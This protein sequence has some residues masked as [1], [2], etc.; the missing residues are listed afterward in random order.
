VLDPFAGT[1]STSIAAVQAGRNS[2]GIEIDS[3]YLEMARERVARA[4]SVRTFI[5]PLEAKISVD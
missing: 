5:G 3:T 1:G 2:I 4:C